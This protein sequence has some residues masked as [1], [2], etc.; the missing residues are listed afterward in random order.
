MLP[1]Y[2]RIEEACCAFAAKRGSKFAGFEKKSRSLFKSRPDS[3][4]S[5][6]NSK[7]VSNKLSPKRRFAT[8]SKEGGSPTA[9][10]AA[11]ERWMRLTRAWKWADTH[12]LPKLFTSYIIIMKRVRKFYYYDHHYWSSKKLLSCFTQNWNRPISHG[13]SFATI[14]Q[15]TAAQMMP[16][17]GRFQKIAI[18]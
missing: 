11:E 5:V 7:A 12:T 2:A 4:N 6:C 10:E 8:E 15:K 13:A 3:N 16:G 1:S 17:S 9:A 14:D 18:Q